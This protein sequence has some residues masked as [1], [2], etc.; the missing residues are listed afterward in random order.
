LGIHDFTRVVVVVRFD[1]LRGLP[2]KLAD[3]SLGEAEAVEDVDAVVSAI[4]RVAPVLS[5]SEIDDW[6]G[7]RVVRRLAKGAT[8]E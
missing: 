8:G 7:G 2:S 4:S 1:V 3:W 6:S 5:I